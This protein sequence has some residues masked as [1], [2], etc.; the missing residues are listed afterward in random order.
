MVCLC[1][2]MITGLFY[3]HMCVDFTADSLDPWLMDNVFSILVLAGWGPRRHICHCCSQ[4]APRA[5]EPPSSL[6]PGPCS[7]PPTRT[8]STCFSLSQSS[9]LC[10]HNALC[11][12]CIIHSSL[13]HT[14]YPSLLLFPLL[15]S[16]P[17]SSPMMVIL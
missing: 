10:H 1:S 12:S 5:W 13:S 17:P 9:C 16:F 11:H 2:E 15:L 14:H 8:N 3:L 6:W 7:V 4:E